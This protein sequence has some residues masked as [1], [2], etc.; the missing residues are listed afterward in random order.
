MTK[1][2]PKF[3]AKCGLP[4][5]T[6]KEPIAFNEMTG[7]PCAWS[8]KCPEFKF[9]PHRMTGNG[10]TYTGTRYQNRGAI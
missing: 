6:S 3:C 9:R 5:V 8:L 1:H 4:L 10:H 2:Y 7:K